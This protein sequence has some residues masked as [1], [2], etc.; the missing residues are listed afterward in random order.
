M[1]LCGCG[2]DWWISQYPDG[3]SFHGQKSAAGGPYNSVIWS[4][5]E[6]GPNKRF[7]LKVE[8]D[9]KTWTAEDLEP[10]KFLKSGA[11]DTLKETDKYLGIPPGK[12]PTKGLATALAY[13]STR[14]GAD[15]ACNYDSKSGEL[16]RV[17]IRLERGGKGPVRITLPQGTVTLPTSHEQLT[18]QLGDPAQLKSGRNRLVM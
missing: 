1:G 14:S 11:I 17:E 4:R 9:G 15:F 7:P 2:P 8:I 5:L 16:V 18:R 3:V 6:A 12:S 10:E 13:R